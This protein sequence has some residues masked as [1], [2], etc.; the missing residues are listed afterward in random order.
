MRTLSKIIWAMGGVG[1]VGVLVSLGLMMAGDQLGRRDEAA[2]RVAV[3]DAVRTPFVGVSP[4]ASP[5]SSSAQQS[6][7]DVPHLLSQLQ[8]ELEAPAEEVVARASQA[9]TVVSDQERLI[10]RQQILEATHGNPLQLLSQT[11]LVP[12]LNGSQ[13]GLRIA[14][15]ADSP[16][17]QKV[18]VQAGDIVTAINGKPVLDP[19]QLGEI[20]S[21]VF[22]APH[23]DVTIQRAG[24]EVTLQYHMEPSAHAPMGQGSP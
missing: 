5:S 16:W 6:S 15:V 13:S 4:A 2:L 18:G 7:E 8:G 11:P 12:H 22:G 20:A 3:P 9:V 17:A 23:L 19:R 21:E 10:D 14:S 24:R 1:S